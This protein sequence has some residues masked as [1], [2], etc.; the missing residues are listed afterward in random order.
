[1]N[2][3][4]PAIIKVRNVLTG[5]IMPFYQQVKEVTVLPTIGNANVLY[6]IITGATTFTSHIYSDGTWHGADGGGAVDS[7]NTKTGAVVLTTGDIS[8]DTD[9]NYVTDA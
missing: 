1:M 3:L 6:I 8:E 4:S 2:T 7:V 5:A 9:A